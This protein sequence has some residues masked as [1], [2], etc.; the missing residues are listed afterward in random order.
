MSCGDCIFSSWLPSVKYQCT[1]LGEAREVMAAHAQNETQYVIAKPAMHVLEILWKEARISAAYQSKSLHV[2]GQGLNL[3]I[4]GKISLLDTVDRSVILSLLLWGGV[5]YIFQGELLP[6]ELDGL[7]CPVGSP[8][9]VLGGSW[10][11]VVRKHSIS[12]K[13]KVAFDRLFEIAGLEVGQSESEENIDF[14]QTDTIGWIQ[15]SFRIRGET[16][17]W[18]AKFSTGTWSALAL[19]ARWAKQEYVGGLIQRFYD[20][21]RQERFDGKTRCQA[22]FGQTWRKALGVVN[23]KR[24]NLSFTVFDQL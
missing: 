24:K 12:R 13:P 15:V 22:D 11:W 14:N 3:A 1:N 20:P 23:Q 21:W 4:I 6:C 8:R 18:R 10:S 9:I 5:Y 2:S 17:I 19:F 7:W 16:Q